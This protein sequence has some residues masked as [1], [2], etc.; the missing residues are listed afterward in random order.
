[1][2]TWQD[3]DSACPGLGDLADQATSAAGRAVDSL[4]SSITN[5]PTSGSVSSIA[6][7]IGSAIDTVKAEAEQQI[8]NVK[9]A[10]A[11]I[12]QTLQEF[13]EETQ[14]LIED[15]E[16]QLVGAIGEVREQLLQQIENAKAALAEVI[17]P[18]LQKTPDE[19]L[20]DVVNRVCDP[21]VNGLGKPTE[22]VA[23][24]MIPA[25]PPAENPAGTAVEV[26]TPPAK[27]PLQT[28][29]IKL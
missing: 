26:F 22:G 13:A 15:L 28:N 27:P 16:Q 19:L 1:M 9:G 5:S 18:W 12:E 2:T 29:P 14:A 10:V 11:E 6:S 7:K 23:K 17:P 4:V 3:F 24:K 21:K 25:T 8:E 20:Q